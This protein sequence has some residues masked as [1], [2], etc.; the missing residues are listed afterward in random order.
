MKNKELLGDLAPQNPEQERI[1]R[2]AIQDL[3]AKV[4]KE[5]QKKLQNSKPLYL[6]NQKIRSKTD[7]FSKDREMR[8]I[9]LIPPE[10][11]EIARKHYG[12]DVLTDKKKFK[13]AFVKDEMGRLCL[14]VDP[15][16]I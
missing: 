16:T 9:A 3:L 14:T 2:E 4:A 11:Y 6:A 12:D 8:M 7:G 15:K 13:E 10:M 1:F 5:K